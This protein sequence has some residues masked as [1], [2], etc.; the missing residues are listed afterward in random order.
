MLNIVC[1]VLLSVGIERDAPGENCFRQLNK[2]LNICHAIS[3][4]A[5]KIIRAVLFCIPRI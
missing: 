4:L 1:E 3:R 2:P 5:L